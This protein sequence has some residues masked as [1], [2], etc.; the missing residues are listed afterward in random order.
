MTN[1]FSFSRLGKLIN[2]VFYEISRLYFY[3]IIAMLALLSLSFTFWISFTGP[4]YS[5]Q[6]TYVIYLL[7]LF[8]TGTIFAS[9]TFNMLGNKDKG[10]YWLSIPATHFEKLICT[11]IFTVVLFFIAYCLCFITVK[12]I[13]VIFLKEYI[14]GVPGGSY[15]ELG[16]VFNAFDGAIKYFLYAYFA[17][18]S[19][20]F[21]GSI[22]FKRYAFIMTSIVAALLLFAFGFYITQIQKNMLDNG[23]WDMVTLIKRDTGSEDNYYLYSV[24]P[25]ISNTLL[26]LLKFV[27]APVLWFITWFKLKEKEI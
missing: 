20:F 8:I 25:A 22:Y 7:G 18:Q 1:S 27:W 5:E 3:S 10:L 21:L 6:A 13:A 9:M 14:K 2:K 16:S 24:S 4:Q 26:F 11:L 15:K 12:T 23:A 19:L 17:I